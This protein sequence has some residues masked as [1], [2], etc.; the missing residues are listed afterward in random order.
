MAKK[1]KRNW[2]DTIKYLKWEEWSRL[3]NSIDNDRDRL[4]IFLLYDTGMMVRELTRLRIED[5]DFG[6]RFVTIRPENTK[7]KIGRRARVPQE[8]L[9]RIIAYLR[10]TRKRK[11]RLFN[12]GPR[13]IQQL[14]KKYSE[15]AG[16]KATPHTLR[17]TY[18]AHALLDRVPIIAIRNQVG[19]KRLTTIQIYSG[20]VAEYR[21]RIGS[22]DPRWWRLH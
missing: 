8:D 15:K 17:H 19:H 16:V 10:L 22:R 12:L 11:G 13:R 4:I 9:N 21:K 3:R 6:R 14:L 2:T 1:Q 5:I 18:I 7:T 20:L